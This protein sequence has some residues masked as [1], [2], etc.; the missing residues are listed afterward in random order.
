M[1][2]NSL[3]SAFRNPSDEAEQLRLIAEDPALLEEEDD[4]WEAWLPLHNAARW[5]ASAAAVRAAV[6]R[7]VGRL[8]LW[9]R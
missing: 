5:G 3:H 9:S 7:V 1:P 6:A 4:S 2:S 8:W